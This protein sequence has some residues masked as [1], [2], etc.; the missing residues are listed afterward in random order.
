LDFGKSRSDE[1]GL[2]ANA[3]KTNQSRDELRERFMREAVLEAELARGRTHPN[4]I[5]GA[6]VVKGGKIVG[7]GH[8]EK[9]GAP[10]AEVIA[11]R[12]AGAKARGAD[13]F[14][15]LE[16]CNHTGRTPPCTEAILAAGITRVFVGTRDPNRHVRGAGAERL[17]AAGVEVELGV[18]GAL[19]DAMNEPWLKFIETGMPWVLLKAAAT[20][21]GKLA[22]AT[23]DSRWVTGEAAR[24]LVHVLR[25]EMDAVLVGINTVLKDDPQLTSRLDATI[26]SGGRARMGRMPSRDPVRVIVDARA[27]MPIGSRM[28]IQK[29]AAATLIATTSKAPKAKLRALEKAGAE[30]LIC[31]RDREGRVELRDLL[32]KLGARGLTSL[33]VEG[34]AAI[35]G[36]FLREKLW[37]ELYLFQA[38]KLAGAGAMSWAG[39]AGSDAMAEALQVRIE[40]VSTEGYA[41]DLLI[42]ARPVR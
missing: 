25:D 35:H 3:G 5:V 24:Q 19:C 18:A 29:S 37:D 16:P 7:R 21:D 38:P 13:L 12:E 10:H 9:A 22:T 42:R 36:S 41:P 11:L 8:H 30:I 14:V 31:E 33:L 15:T 40:Q 20:L 39:F 34:G 4:P 28:L 23:G 26:T 2:M 1:D 17:R 6:I 27:N 32:R